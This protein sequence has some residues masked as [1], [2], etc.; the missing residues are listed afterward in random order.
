[1]VASLDQLDTF[2]TTAATQRYH[3]IDTSRTSGGKDALGQPGSPDNLMAQLD[4]HFTNLTSAATNSNSA[5]EQLATATADP[6]TEIKLSLDTLA[7]AP[8][9][10]A[11]APGTRSRA[12]ALP[13]T[14]KRKLEKWINMIKATVKHSWKVRGFCST[15]GHC[16]G[17]GHIRK[18]LCQ[19][20][21]QPH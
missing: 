19:Q 7:A 4:R 9:N 3:G 10:P 5:F 6:Y 8:H 16:V 17:A 15:Y 14:K 18:N 13:I 12:T 21:I 20:R 11:P 1:M 2:G